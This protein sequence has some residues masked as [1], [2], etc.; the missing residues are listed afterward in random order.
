MNIHKIHSIQK[1][2]SL[3]LFLVMGLS[4]QAQEL[5]E[6]PE[7][8][9]PRWFSFENITGAKGAG[10]QENIGAKGHPMDWVRAGET[11][12]LMEME[13]SGVINRIWLTISDRS[14]EMLRS[15]KL[16]M[17]WDGEDRPA[18]A[19]PLGDFFGIGLGRRVAFE[20]ALFSDPEGRSFNS[21]I[22]MPFKNGA[23]VTI[24]NESDTDLKALF[25]DIN[26]QKKEFDDEILYFHTY[27]NRELE[28]ELGKDFEI[29]PKVEGTGRFLGTNMGIFT[30]EEYGE[31]W[32]GEGEV[33]MY[34]DG[35]GEF[36]TLI[37]TGTEDYIGTA[38]GQGEYANWYQGAPIADNEKFEQ[39]F[40]RYH[41][42]DPIYFYEDITVTIQQM[43]GWPTEQVRELVKNGAVLK[44]V[45]VS[46]N[47]M[48]IKLLELKDQPALEDEDFPMG[49]TNFY[50]NDDVS[51]TAYFYLDKPANSLPGIQP[52][53]ERTAE[54]HE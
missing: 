53:A 39:A 19:A 2:S 46:V 50:R 34:I 7:G 15:L 12:T 47:D 49:W 31:S 17:Y 48:I 26:V 27:W 3:V 10:G 30:G 5:Y 41:L 35:D 9:E 38:W 42:P 23:K 16:E 29:L 52:V 32:W 13:G 37:G 22:P 8:E 4:L 24:T 18:V 44:P 6:K 1:V 40:Y 20:N 36:P 11:V 45:T 28:T 51:S 21:V 43:G 54:L 14:P 25:Y 33:K